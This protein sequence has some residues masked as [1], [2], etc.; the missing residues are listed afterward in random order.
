MAETSVVSDSLIGV[1]GAGNM[2]SGIAQK[3]AT[4][5]FRVVVLDMSDEAAQRGRERVAQT[6]EEGVARKI[7][8][9]EKAA[10]ILERMT[11]T[12]DRNELK[13]A[14]LIVEA[15]FE[16]KNIKRELFAA[17]D[18]LCGPETLLATNTSSF[19]V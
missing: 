6:L 12:A 3:Y 16:D 1:V 19:Y 13:D 7:F 4:E 8:S 17:L 9:P 14:S 2:G 11:F 18:A 15:I 5:G 10:A